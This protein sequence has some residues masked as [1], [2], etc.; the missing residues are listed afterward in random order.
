MNKNH[1]RTFKVL[2]SEKKLTHTE[3]KIKIKTKKANTCL[4]WCTNF[5]EKQD[6]Y[7]CLHSSAIRGDK[8]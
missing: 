4:P 5:G 3:L 1:K 6:H 2:I 7:T 8:F